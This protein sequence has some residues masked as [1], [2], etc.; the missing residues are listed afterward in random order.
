MKRFLLL[1][2]T[3][4]SVHAQDAG[5]LE[6]KLV[7]E[8]RLIELSELH[9]LQA[10]KRELQAQVEAAAKR[11]DSLWIGNVRVTPEQKEAYDFA[12]SLNNR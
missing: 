12:V 11:D 7:T 2:V 9:Q 5:Y 4:A 10:Q 8:G 6:Y 3:C 1:L